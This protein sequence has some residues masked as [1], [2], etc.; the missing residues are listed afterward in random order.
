MQKL[1]STQ[2]EHIY[3][4]AV[5]YVICIVAPRNN[6]LHDFVDGDNLDSSI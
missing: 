3:T 5:R 4:K 6:A 2:T 1:A